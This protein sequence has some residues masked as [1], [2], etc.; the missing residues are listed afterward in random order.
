MEENKESL[1]KK[2]AGN[3]EEV[4]EN[5]KEEKVSE[6]ETIKKLDQCCKEEEKSRSEIVRECIEE[7]YNRIKK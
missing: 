4:K 6:E 2:D 3:G 1:N 5:K 7:K